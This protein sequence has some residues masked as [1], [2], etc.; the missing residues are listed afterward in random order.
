MSES[1]LAYFPSAFTSIRLEPRE[2]LEAGG[3]YST[4]KPGF[5]VEPGVEES[6]YLETR[7]FTPAEFGVATELPY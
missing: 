7:L 6:C 5:Q 1:K 4:E 3:D 2:N